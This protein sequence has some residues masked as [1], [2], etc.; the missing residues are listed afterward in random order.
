MNAVLEGVVK[1]ILLKF[2]LNGKYKNYQFYLLN[3]VKNIDKI[4]LGI[5]PPH[6][7]RQT[8]QSMEKNT[9]ILESFRIACLTIVLFYSNPSAFSS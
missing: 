2:M 1:T 6:E 4:L 8:P 3:K 9:E 7:F 5:K